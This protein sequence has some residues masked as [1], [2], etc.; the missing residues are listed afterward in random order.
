MKD[1]SRFDQVLERFTEDG[2]LP[3]VIAGLANRDGTLYTGA[4]GHSNLELGSPMETDAILAIASMTKLVTTVAVLQLVDQGLLD[5]DAPITDYLPQFQVPKVLEGFSASGEPVLVE[6]SS[7]PTTR[8]LLTHTSGYVYEI[9]NE[10]ALKSVTSGLVPGLLDAG[11]DALSAP[12][13]FSPG[14]R[15]EYGIGIDWAGIILETI[16]GKNLDSYFQDHLFGP[17]KM[18]DTF[19]EIPGSKQARAASTYSRTSGGFE[20]SPPLAPMIMGGG[21]LYSTISDYL[22]FARVL[23]ND[24]SL[25]GVRIL[26]PETVERMFENQIGEL[27]VTPGTTRM[28]ELSNDFDMGFGAPARWGLGLLLHDRQTPAGRPAGSA[29][30]AG[31]FN[32]YFWIDRENSLCAVVGTQVLPF[33]DE[34]AVALLKAYEEAVYQSLP[35]PAM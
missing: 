26:N 16:T 22:R 11:L 20:F 3:G 24:G 19:Y 18:N 30:W 31:L 27:S 23:L 15:W 28:P 4:S 25:D 10:N 5:L 34:Q 8:A 35:Q 1:E 7:V 32:T 17:L 33:Y 21:G 14:T 12:L 9:W 6:P 29:S 13:A 2:L